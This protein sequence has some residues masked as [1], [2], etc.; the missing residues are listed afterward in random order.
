VLLSQ[1]TLTIATASKNSTYD[2]LAQSIKHIVETNSEYK[3]EILHTKGSVENIKLLEAKK[4]QL[5]IVQNDTASYAKNGLAPFDTPLLDL[6]MLFSFYDEPIYIITNKPNINGIGQLKNMR[7]NVGQKNSGLLAS[8]KVLLNS[9]NLWEYTTPFYYPPAKSLKYLEDDKVQ[10]VFV[11]T[12]SDE[13]KEKIKAKQ[14]YVVPISTRI[15]DRLQKTFSYFSNFK[16]DDNAYSLAVKAIFIAH[17]GIDEE[18]TYHITKMLYEHYDALVFPVEHKDKSNCF[19]INPLSSWHGG[20]EQFFSEYNIA[21]KSSIGNDYII[22]GLG[23]ALLTLFLIMFLVVYIIHRRS[24][25]YSVTPSDNYLLNSFKMMYLKVIDH[26]YLVFVIVVLSLYLVCIFLIKYV[27]HRWALTNNFSSA[28]DDFSFKDS[29]MWLFLFATSNYSGGV[30]PHSDWGKFFASIIPMIGW[31]GLLAFA[32][33]LASDKIKQFLLEVKGMGSIKYNNHII[34]CGW[35]KGGCNIIEALTHDNIEN[36]HDIVVLAEETYKAEIDLCILNHK[37]ITYLVGKAKSKDDLERAN[38]QKANAVLVL[39]DDNH[40]DPDAYAILDVLTISKCANDL[41]IREHKG[42]QFQ[43]I[44]QLHAYQNKQIALDAGADQVISMSNVESNILANMIQ[45]PGVNN[46]IEEIFDF[47]DTNDI[48]SIDIKKG[49]KLIGKTY[50]EALILLREHNV[51]LLSINIAY[52]RSEEEMDRIKKENGLTREV[53]TNPINEKE[54][55][56]KIQEGGMLI[57][58]AQYGHTVSDAVKKLE[59]GL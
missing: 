11:N 24:L 37:N 1:Q 15:I 17:Q 22:Y 25:K 7:I 55:N 40:A 3:I 6:Q 48:Y 21:P 41:G 9:T 5:A 46:L 36:Q 58:L 30:F 4:V 10:A 54:N 47:N 23:A 16:I 45:T 51:L 29:L 56:Y 26:K 50:N 42:H 28:F 44:I 53:I 59:S 14:W 32:T 43:I 2:K 13:I 8:A 52:Y 33:L 19:G 35:N 34:L 27:E 49:S 18:V 12:L 38:L 31:G 20:T 39:Q 57:V